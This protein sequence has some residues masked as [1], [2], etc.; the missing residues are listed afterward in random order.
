VKSIENM[1]IHLTAEERDI[2]NGKDGPTMQRVMKTLV[3]YADALGADRLVDI[4]GDGHFVIAWATPGIAP[5]FKL[6]DELI[7]AG[8]K[9]KLPF[10]LDPSAPLDFTNWNLRQDQEDLLK[11]LYKDQERYNEKML[12]IGLRDQD[13]YTCNPFEPEVGNIPEKGAILA[14]SESACAIYANSVLSARTNKNGAIIDLLSYIAGKTPLAGLMTDE[15][16]RADSIVE[17]NTNFLPNP[18]ILGAL[19]GARVLDGVPYIVGLDRFLGRELSEATV[20]YLREM[21]AA[22]ATYSAIALFHVENITPEAFEQGRALLINDQSH[23]QIDDADVREFFETLSGGWSGLESD[24]EK[25]FIGCP[26]LSSQQ[27]NW[28]AEKLLQRLDLQD[29]ECLAVKTTICAALGVIERFKSD[30]AM[31][32]R[33]LDVGVRF[34][35]SCPETLFEGGVSTNDAIITNSSKLKA[36]STARFFP[37]EELV[38]ILVGGGN[39]DGG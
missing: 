9:A 13:A 14:W 25:C 30:R 10:T 3:D 15:G 31:Y 7:A 11:E 38:D 8:L 23:I 19:I 28:W 20:D 24:P 18:Q 36:Y 32:E 37:D 26:H 39:S 21:G 16:R 29:K 4:D 12:Q 35:H 34:S 1:N 6:L 17:V 2:L 27:L 33:L 22:C 5:S